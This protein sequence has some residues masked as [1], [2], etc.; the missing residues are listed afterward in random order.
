MQTIWL[1]LQNNWWIAALALG[2]IL[3]VLIIVRFVFGRGAQAKEPAKPV[4]NT[5]DAF[6]EGIFGRLTPALAGVIPESRQ[7]SR[8]FS[9]LLRR[10][11]LYSTGT[12]SSIFAIRFVACDI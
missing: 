11:G 2:L 8:D 10:A 12:R 4:G 1:W 9:Q 3:L 6:Q 5:E 7:E